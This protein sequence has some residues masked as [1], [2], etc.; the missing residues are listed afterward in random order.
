MPQ[1]PIR[2]SLVAE[3]TQARRSGRL[4][5]ADANVGRVTLEH[6]RVYL[7]SGVMENVHI[8]GPLDAQGVRDEARKGLCS[9]VMGSA[10]R[11]DAAKARAGDDHGSLFAVLLATLKHLLAH[12]LGEVADV[13]AGHLSHRLNFRVIQVLER[14]HLADTCVED[15]DGN[16][17]SAEL[18]CNFVVALKGSHAAKVSDNL[19]RLDMAFLFNLFATGFHLRC[20]SCHNANVEALR[21]KIVSHSEAN[22]IRAASDYRPRVFATI[23]HKG[24]VLRLQ[25]WPDSVPLNHR[26]EAVSSL[27]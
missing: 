21:R 23:T 17:K 15:E 24:V 7:A 2:I 26:E 3:V 10:S 12:G 22:S 1:A 4:S 14:A 13:D 18:P 19:H 16:I 11:W 8:F 27:C 5:R 25:D 6:L 9:G 20:V